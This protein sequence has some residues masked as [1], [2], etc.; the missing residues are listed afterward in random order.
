MRYEVTVQDR[1][2]SVDLSEGPDGALRVR[3]DGG[4]ERS[5][6]AQ[7]LGAAEWAL[8][9]GGRSQRVALARSGDDW[10][11]QRQGASVHGR[12]V[13]P[14][15]AALAMDGGAG[16]GGVATQMPGAVVRVLVAVGDAVRKGQPL[17]VVEAMKMENEFKAPA[18]GVVEAVHV[19]AG[20]SVE[21]G[22]VLVSVKLG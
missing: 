9:E 22:T 13:D 12:V 8:V 21:A 16:E 3:V 1:I 18:D 4:P 19:S 17:V 14:R 15:R 10:F 11:A 20:Q 7:R 2:Y 6:R 5:V